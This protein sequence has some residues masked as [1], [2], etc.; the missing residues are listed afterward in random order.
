MSLISVLNRRRVLLGGGGF[1]EDNYNTIIENYYNNIPDA[2]Y[3][4]TRLNGIVEADV[5]DFIRVGDT[6]FCNIY[7]PYT[8]N[9]RK[10]NIG[11]MP[12]TWIDLAGNMVTS[13]NASL[14]QQQIY[15][16]K[17]DNLQTLHTYVLQ[18]TYIYYLELPSLITMLNGAT[19]TSYN[20]VVGYFKNLTSMGT[21]NFRLASAIKYIYIPNC[22]LF[23]GNN[24]LY[25]QVF[26]DMKT[27]CK[28]YI[29]PSMLTINA[30][31]LEADLAYAQSSR[32]AV[33]IPVTNTTANIDSI[34]DLSI[35]GITSVGGVINFS[36]P[37]SD[38]G[39]NHYEVYAMRKSYSKKD[40]TYWIDRNRIKAEIIASGQ[41]ITNLISGTEYIIKIRAWD[42]QG[43]LSAFSNEIEFTTL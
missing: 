31:G 13:I 23:G 3:L 40:I 33:I 32:A 30:G 20:M 2:A 5:E 19:Y 25:T 17:A 26:R 12:R 35:S 14:Q 1:N 41:S 6:I 24:T 42:I 43:N 38:L 11:Y 36:V 8:I 21:I 9:M 39:V 37:L 4:A 10:S 15:A 22:V 27:G 16:F 29:H 34:T 28:I 18:K 7:K